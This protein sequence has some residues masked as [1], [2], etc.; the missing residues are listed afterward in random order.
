MISFSSNDRTVSNVGL[1]AWGTSWTRAADEERRKAED[2]RKLAEPE[3]VVE[4]VDECVDVDGDDDVFGGGDCC[5]ADFVVVDDMA[6]R[7]NTGK[8]RRERTRLG[9]LNEK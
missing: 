7:S 5:R 4:S 6:N 8:C 2:L 3:E 9:C 1:R